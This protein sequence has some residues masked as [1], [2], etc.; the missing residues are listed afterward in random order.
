MSHMGVRNDNLGETVDSII[1]GG[2]WFMGEV[3]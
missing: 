2:S 1:G 3:E